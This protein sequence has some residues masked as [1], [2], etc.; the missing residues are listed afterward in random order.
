MPRFVARR[1][2]S[3]ANRQSEIGNSVDLQSLKRWH[4]TLIG[5]IGGMML[6]GGRVLSVSDKQVGG[7]EFIP[8]SQ[9][10]RDLRMSAFGGR[11]HLKGIVIHPAGTVDLVSFRELDTDTD[12]YYPDL[13]WF[14]APRPYKA[15]GALTEPGKE[16]RVSD[17]LDEVKFSYSSAWWETMGGAMTLW[18]IGGGIA[19]GGIWPFILNF[20]VGA[21]LGRKPK[22]EEYDLDRFKSEPAPATK[23]ELS[24]EERKRLE[25][26]EEEIAAGLSDAGDQPRTEIIQAPA[27]RKE[28]ATEVLDQV[29][30]GP[31]E[32]KDY[33]GEYYP[34]EKINSKSEVRNSKQI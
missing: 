14:A 34:V 30:L 20:L 16:N 32:Q 25:E 18:A 27:T 1:A 33:E 29:P 12:D 8:Q 17:F 11:P 26:L 2:F 31:Q 15:L 6:A 28:L 23:K 19:V 3:I 9:F 21:G 5:M 10:E 24:E 22:E 7:K 13:H 4:W